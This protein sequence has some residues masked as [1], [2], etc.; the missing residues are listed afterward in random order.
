MRTLHLALGLLAVL[1]GLGYLGWLGYNILIE[2]QPGFQ[3]R[4]IGQFLFPFLAVG[5]GV[6][7]ILRHRG[8]QT[9]QKNS[10]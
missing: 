4:S 7:W 5:G 8:P 3:L 6:Y 2:A 9:A 1:V 10:N